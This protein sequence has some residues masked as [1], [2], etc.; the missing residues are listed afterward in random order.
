[1]RDYALYKGDEFLCVGSL[2]EVAN[3]Q[4]VKPTTISYLA[5]KAYLRKLEKRKKYD[6]AL[7]AIRLV[8]EDVSGDE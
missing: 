8:D 1:M 2:H 4:G 5:S 7:I 3:Y 6:S